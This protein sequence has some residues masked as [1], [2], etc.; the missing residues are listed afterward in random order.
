MNHFQEIFIQNLRYYRI[1]AGFSQL[2]FSEKIGLSPNYL[3]AIENGKNFPSA[4]VI[5]RILDI[6][7]LLPYQLFLEKPDTSSLQP[8]LREIT[9][10]AS[11]LKQTLIVK[12]DDF[13]KTQLSK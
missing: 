13:V 4:D 7:N 8:D 5:Q 2:A 3:N 9:Q 6:L 12:I 1:K 10:L 11:S